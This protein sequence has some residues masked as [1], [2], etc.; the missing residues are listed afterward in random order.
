MIIRDCGVKGNPETQPPV[1]PSW[2]TESIFHLLVSLNRLLKAVI[3]KTEKQVWKQNLWPTSFRFISQISAATLAQLREMNINCF[4]SC[5][6]SFNWGITRV[7]LAS[8]EL[9]KHLRFL[10]SS[11]IKEK[12]QEIPESHWLKPGSLLPHHCCCVPFRCTQSPR[13]PLHDD[14]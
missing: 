2:K 12:K 14:L 1:T 9:H 10:S 13:R 7:Q 11:S 3:T 6:L 5:S 4:Q 8:P